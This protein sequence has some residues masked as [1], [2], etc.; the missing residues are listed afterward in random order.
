MYMEP[1]AIQMRPKNIDEVIGQKHLLGNKMP[2]Y[3]L[4]QNKYLFSMILYGKPGIGKTTIALAIAESL[5]IKYRVLNAVINSKKDFDIVIEEAKLYNG[6]IVIIDEIHRMNK[7]KQDLLLPYLESGIITLIGL[8]TSNPYHRINP[9]IRSRCQIFEL[10]ELE[11][12]D[13]IY[14]LNKAIKSNILNDIKIDENAINMIA[15]LSNGD[16]RYAYN[17]LEF[18][19]FASSDK[20]ITID[21]LQNINAKSNVSIDKNEDGHYDVISAFQKSIRGSDVNAS[22]HYLARLIEAGDL[23]IIYRRMTVIAYEDIGL[24]NPSIGPKVDA[25]IN[26][27][28]RLGLPEARIPLGDMVIEMALSPKSNSGHIALDKAINDVRLGN[29]GPV[30]I[31]IKQNPVGY[32]YPHDYPNSWVKQ[33]YLP[34]NIKN[35]KYYNPKLTSKYEQSLKNVYDKIEKNNN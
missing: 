1:L 5:K 8:T 7:D 14:A 19:Y 17:L 31:N 24:A 10:K 2:L 3:N 11:K 4:I 34:D 35:K 18:A 6:M 20:N 15:D 30:P 21:H 28:E 26:A 22:L 27:C 29:I 32:K 9:A 25:V 33:Q 16:L 13:I 23:D 12:E